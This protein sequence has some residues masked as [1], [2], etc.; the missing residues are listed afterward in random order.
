MHRDRTPGNICEFHI[1]PRP[2]LKMHLPLVSLAYIGVWNISHLSPPPP[3]PPTA[4]QTP[5][6]YMLYISFTWN[7]MR[8]SE[9]PK[10][11]RRSCAEPFPANPTDSSRSQPLHFGS[12]VIV[13]VIL[14]IWCCQKRLPD[15]DMKQRHAQR[16]LK[17]I[18]TLEGQKKGV[19]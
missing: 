17:N 3:H 13:H 1:N 2:L 18:G 9:N 11:H 5:S 16:R 8:L 15:G 19:N 10:Q 6:D 14:R 4:E 12:H 7:T